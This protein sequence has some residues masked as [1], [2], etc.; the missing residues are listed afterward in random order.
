M[1]G[2][3]GGGGRRRGGG[4]GK[5][6]GQEG[7]GEGE[8]EEEGSEGPQGQRRLGLGGVKWERGLSKGAAY[9]NLP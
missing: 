5:G 3:G 1:P 4:E 2:P 9:P 7:V 6:K 8:R